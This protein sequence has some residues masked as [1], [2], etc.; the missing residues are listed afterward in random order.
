[1]SNNQ[2][3]STSEPEFELDF[4][5]ANNSLCEPSVWDLKVIFGQLEQHTGQTRIDWH[6]AVTM[7]WAQ[8]KLLSYYIRLNIAQHEIQFGGLKSPPSITPARPSPPAGK[9]K[10]NP[11]ELQFYEMAKAIHEEMFAEE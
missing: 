8:A 11:D 3:D 4:V 10:G 7:P 9:L 1:M 5:Y 2:L 6:T